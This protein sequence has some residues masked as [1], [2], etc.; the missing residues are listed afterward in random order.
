[1]E[2]KGKEKENEKKEK[3]ENK[4]EKRKGRKN[5]IAKQ[6]YFPQLL[7]RNTVAVLRYLIFYSFCIPRVAEN[8]SIFLYY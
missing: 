1:M 4:S 6:Y 5:N 2:K 7:R 8:R 3:G